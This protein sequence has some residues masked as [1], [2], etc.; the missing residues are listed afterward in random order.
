MHRPNFIP[1]FVVEV[2]FSFHK[3]ILLLM[4]RFVNDFFYQNFSR[5]GSIQ[6]LIQYEK[7]LLNW[8]LFSVWN[9]HRRVFLKYVD[10]VSRRQ[11][12]ATNISFMLE[13]L[14]KWAIRIVVVAIHSWQFRIAMSL[15]WFVKWLY[16]FHCTIRW[17]L[18][19]SVGIRDID[20]HVAVEGTLLGLVKLGSRRTMF[21]GLLGILNSFRT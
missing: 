5:S 1:E 8:Y 17:L 19:N 14:K 18:A 20:E 15:L 2:V 7:L 13:S 21:Y 4:F 16:F 6:V 11:L 9:L 3:I 12:D 10:L